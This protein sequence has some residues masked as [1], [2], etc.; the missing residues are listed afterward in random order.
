MRRSWRDKRPRFDTPTIYTKE[1]A[2]VT[3]VRENVGYGFTH[4]TIIGTPEQIAKVQDNIYTNYHPAGYSTIVY[5][6]PEQ[7]DKFAED[8]RPVDLGNGRW[9]VKGWRANSC[10]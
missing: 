2:E 4:Y 7:C 8:V 6:P 3:E 5:W 9:Q 1:G 10:D